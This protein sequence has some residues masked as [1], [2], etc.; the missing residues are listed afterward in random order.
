MN[1]SLNVL[2][3]V[4]G[5][6]DS[7]RD[8]IFV[9]RGIGQYQT[10][11]INIHVFRF[12]KRHSLLGFISSLFLVHKLIHDHKIDIVHSHYGTVT[13]LLGLLSFKKHMVTFRGS[14]VNPDSKSV[15]RQ[16]IKSFISNLI[17]RFSFKVV[18]VSE[19]ISKR[20]FILPNDKLIIIPSG[21]M[22]S[23]FIPMNQYDCREQLKLS[24]DKIYIAFAPSGGRSLKRRD[25]AEIVVE[26]VKSLGF[27]AELL[28][29]KDLEESE[30]PVLLNAANCL[31][32]TSDSEGSPNIVREALCCGVPVFSF[33]VGDVSKWIRLD[34]L[35]AVC[36]DVDDIIQ[37]VIILLGGKSEKRRRVD[38]SQFSTETVVTKYV[39]IYKREK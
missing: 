36:S 1:N 6:K 9:Y 7:K 8:F 31:I 22:T 15:I 17:A 21:T 39:S 34:P 29:V 16:L 23:V 3:I 35:S 18:C 38:V 14:D 25:L 13:G 24:K 20:L 19:A 10:L 12:E 11:G 27:K 28:E 26:N 37:K 2:W 4:P 32:L 30:V 5:N 33:D